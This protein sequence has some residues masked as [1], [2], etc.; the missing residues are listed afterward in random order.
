MDSV[1]QYNACNDIYYTEKTTQLVKDFTLVVARQ[2]RDISNQPGA[3]LAGCDKMINTLNVLENI[4]KENSQVPIDKGA[5]AMVNIKECFN[6]GMIKNIT[7]QSTELKVG[8]LSVEDTLNAVSKC[9][10]HDNNFLA[11]NSDDQKNL[12]PAYSAA[13]KDYLLKNINSY[14]ALRP[15]A[16]EYIRQKYANQDFIDALHKQADHI[17]PHGN[18]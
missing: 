3:P 18:D 12:L 10:V 14:K 16:R 15:N 5:A 6:E 13:D 9:L 1:S 17:K 8:I 2:I 7:S 11:L 4:A